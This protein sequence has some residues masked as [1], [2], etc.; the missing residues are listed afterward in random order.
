[1][2]IAYLDVNV[3]ATEGSKT[4]VYRGGSRIWGKG[5]LINIFT[6]GGR[7]LGGA[8]IALPVGSGAKLLRLFSTVISNTYMYTSRDIRITRACM[9]SDEKTVHSSQ[10]Y[11]S[12]CSAI[13]FVTQSFCEFVTEACTWPAT[14]RSINDSCMFYY[15][16]SIVSLFSSIAI[17]LLRKRI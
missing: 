16:I 5:G 13:K 10:C 17:C 11:G 3:K 12:Y 14:C 1:M 6:T 9:D 2:C 7:V 4:I 8:L 15:N